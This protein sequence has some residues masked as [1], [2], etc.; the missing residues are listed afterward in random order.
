M[1]IRSPHNILMRNWRS[2]AS[3]FA[4]LTNPHLTR[5]QSLSRFKAAVRLF[6]PD[7]QALALHHGM[8]LRAKGKRIPELPEAA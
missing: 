6:P 5:E 8:E 4:A 2:T 7:A 1:S 3:A